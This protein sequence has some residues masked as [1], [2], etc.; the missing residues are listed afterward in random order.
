MVSHALKHEQLSDQIKTLVRSESGCN[1][2]GYYSC[3]YG[4]VTAFCEKLHL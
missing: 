3:A 4:T 1:I 2:A